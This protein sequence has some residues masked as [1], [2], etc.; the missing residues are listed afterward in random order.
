MNIKK[1]KANYID[2]AKMY[3]LVVRDKEKGVLSDELAKMLLL[4][5]DRYSHRPSFFGYTYREDLVGNAALLL[6]RKWMMF[7][8]EQSTQ[9]FS[10]YTSIVHNSFLH[11]LK[12]ENKHRDLRDNLLID[13]GMDPSF[14]RQLR[15]EKPQ[16]PYDR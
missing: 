1:K 13:V 3:E 7:D 16:S 6:C 10:Y 4:I 5:A 12:Y 2:K 14:A 11:T 15:D 8:H 9:A